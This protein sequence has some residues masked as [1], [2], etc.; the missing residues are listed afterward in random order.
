MRKYML[1]PGRT[2]SQQDYDVHFITA[3]ELMRLYRVKG[4]ECSIC[5]ACDGRQSA[6]ADWIRK[7]RCEKNNPR[8]IHLFPKYDG[9]YDI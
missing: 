2:L 4:L 8:F 9:C 3:S 5:H 1:H 6:N 7:E